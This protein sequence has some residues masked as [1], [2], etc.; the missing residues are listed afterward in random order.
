MTNLEVADH[1]KNLILELDLERDKIHISINKNGREI[2]GYVNEQ[3]LDSDKRNN[4]VD[5]NK[6]GNCLADIID[7]C[8]Y[9]LHKGEDITLKTQTVWLLSRK[10]L[11]ESILLKFC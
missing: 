9:G 3:F 11:A 2:G 8:K 10:T 5:K 1:I 4:L 7:E 6:L